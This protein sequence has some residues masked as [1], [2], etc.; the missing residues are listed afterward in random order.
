VTGTGGLHPATGFLTVPDFRE[1]LKSLL[2]LLSEDG[3]LQ[4]AVKL[5]GRSSL[6]TDCD[7]KLPPYPEISIE[8][9]LCAKI[10]SG[11]RHAEVLSK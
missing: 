6:S 9:G 4:I 3:S 5:P 10:N 1:Q 8:L 2:R 11:L 7:N